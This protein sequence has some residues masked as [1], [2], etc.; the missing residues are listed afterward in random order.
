MGVEPILITSESVNPDMSVLSVN[1]PANTQDQLPNAEW[2]L[3]RSKL[4]KLGCIVPPR[5]GYRFLLITPR[6]NRSRIGFRTSLL[7]LIRSI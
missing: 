7:S 4:L 3:A 2:L 5:D 6:V 1:E